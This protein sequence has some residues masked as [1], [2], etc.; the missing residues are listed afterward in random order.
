VTGPDEPLRQC[1]AELADQIGPTDLLDRSLRRSRGIGR[2]RAALATGAALVVVAASGTT[3]ARFGLPGGN[4]APAPQPAAQAP[5]EA[6]RSVA[7]LPGALYYQQDDPERVV[8]LELGGK[9]TPLTSGEDSS[10]TA[11]SPDGRHVAFR[12]P[13][14]QLWVADRDGHA[15]RQIAG[16]VLAED[17]PPVWSPDSARL[18]VIRSADGKRQPV[19]IDLASGAVTPLPG[20]L[21]GAPAAGPA[22]DPPGARFAFAGDGAALLYAT[23]DCVLMV[24]RADGGDA[25]RVPVIGDADRTVNPANTYACEVFS[26]SRDG[27]RVAVQLTSSATAGGGERAADAVVDTTTGA[28]VPLPVVGGVSWLQYRPDGTLLVR[29][30]DDER[31]TLTLLSP[32][33]AVIAKVTEPAALNQLNLVAYTR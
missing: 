12:R 28:V 19:T 8:R 22:N 30:A 4:H 31:S 2:R 1:L 17:Q 20:T 5:L 3:I 7:G 10:T 16:D 27:S 25:R 11:V 14:A 15:A 26:A 32:T 24:A 33:D 21:T 18:Q 9:L 29:S 23:A 13:P 6:A